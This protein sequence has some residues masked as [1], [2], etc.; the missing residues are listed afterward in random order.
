MTARPIIRV[1]DKTT[2]GGTVLEGFSSYDIDGRAAAGLGHKVDCPKCKGV[3]PIIEGVPSFAVGDSLVAIEGMKTA[4]GAAL[5]ASQGFARVDPGPGGV[6]RSLSDGSGLS[7]RFSPGGTGPA[8]P[9]VAWLRPAGCNHTDTAVPLAQYM[10]RE[11]KTNPFTFEGRAIFTANSADPRAR[12]AQWSQLP[13]YLRL[14]E[15]PAF[16]AAAAGQKAAAYGL[17]TERVAP[18]RPWDHKSL[19]RE[20]FVGEIHPLW[21]KYKNHDYFYDIWSNIHY[22]YVGVAVGFSA[23]ELINGAGI[24]QALDDLRRGDSQQYHPENGPWPASADDVPDH[25]SI[26]L[27]TDLYEQVKPHALT[28]GI[29]L[30]LVAAVPVPWGKGKDRAKKVHDC[31]GPL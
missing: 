11:M 29:L 7:P 23:A 28:V 26:K 14:G 27:G 13:W 20:K 18:N 25:M 8:Q 15:P 5:I 4:C 21:H 10:V 6:A 9:H 24:A 3:F 31:R 16:E 1:G 2:H 30:E 22:G 17:W 19:L 12:R